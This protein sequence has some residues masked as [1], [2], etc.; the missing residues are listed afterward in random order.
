MSGALPPQRMLNRVQ[1]LQQFP[2]FECRFEFG[3]RVKKIMPGGFSH[4]RCAIERTDLSDV[5][6]GECVKVR[7]RLVERGGDV[8]EVAPQGDLAQVYDPSGLLI[9][10]ATRNSIS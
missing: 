3:S 8:P 2:R 6:T 4:W 10:T 9:G 7:N 5:D 1:S